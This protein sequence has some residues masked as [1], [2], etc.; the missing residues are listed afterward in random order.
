M[1]FQPLYGF[2]GEPPVFNS[3]HESG[4]YSVDDKEVNLREVAFADHLDELDTSSTNGLHLTG[5]DCS[6]V[7]LC[8]PYFIIK[9]LYMNVFTASQE[10]MWT[11]WK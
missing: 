11:H 9:M 6:I 10:F 2:G 4:L 5:S 8:M 7:L 3:I 1:C